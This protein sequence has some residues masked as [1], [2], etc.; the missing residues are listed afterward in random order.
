MYK[1][2]LEN[3]IAI[4]QVPKFLSFVEKVIEYNANNLWDENNKGEGYFNIENSYLELISLGFNLPKECDY[5]IFCSDL[6]AEILQIR[7]K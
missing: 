5:K 1:N 2:L 7:V 4:N 3:A 6:A